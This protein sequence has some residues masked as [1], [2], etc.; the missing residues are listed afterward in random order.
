MSSVSISRS[1]LNVM[2]LNK[3]AVTIR[4]QRGHSFY[5]L[6]K[7][8]AADSQQSRCLNDDMKTVIKDFLV[9]SPTE[10]LFSLKNSLILLSLSTLCINCFISDWEISFSS[11]ARAVVHSSLT[12]YYLH[13]YITIIKA[14]ST[15][16]I[17][18]TQSTQAL[19]DFRPQSF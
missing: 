3:S 17:S 2:R 8:L 18:I 5:S 4:L 12:L 19:Y 10:R 11:D 6:I 9:C 15:T 13:C 1:A 16:Q 14:I 7:M